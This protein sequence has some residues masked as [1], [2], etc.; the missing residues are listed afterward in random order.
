MIRGA[1]IRNRQDSRFLCSPA[2]AIKLVKKITK[3]QEQTKQILRNLTS[4]LYRMV[5]KLADNKK[6][7]EQTKQTCAAGNNVV[8]E[9][10]GA[11]LAHSHFEGLSFL[12]H[13]GCIAWRHAFYQ[14]S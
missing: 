5:K 6:P 10:D 9:C 8:N 13:E 4:K 7:Y 11:I 14:V 3:S 1:V 12:T 2:C